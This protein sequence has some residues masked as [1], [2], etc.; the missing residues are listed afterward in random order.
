[1]RNPRRTASAKP[2]DLLGR[3]TEDEYTEVAPAVAGTTGRDWH[4][5]DYRASR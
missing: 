5:H 3:N 4:D 2:D 1:M